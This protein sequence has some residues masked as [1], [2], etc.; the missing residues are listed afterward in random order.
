MIVK[1]LFIAAG[2]ALAVKLF[3]HLRKVQGKDK[4]NKKKNDSWLDFQA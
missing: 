1:I 2:S 4:K 3:A